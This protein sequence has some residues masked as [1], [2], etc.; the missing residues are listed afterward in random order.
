[1]WYINNQKNY[2][3]KKSHSKGEEK[4]KIGTKIPNYS[5]IEKKKDG[6]SSIIGWKVAISEIAPIFTT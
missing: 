4:E 6:W 5:S 1:M 2:D 3:K